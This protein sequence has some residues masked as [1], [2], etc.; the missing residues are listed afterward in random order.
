MLTVRKIDERD[1]ESLRNIS[2]QTFNETFF[3][4]NSEQDMQQYI[5]ESLNEERLLFELQNLDSEFYFAEEEGK[6]LGYLKLNFN[7]AQT[8]NFDENHYEVERIYVLKE[9]LRMKIGQF[10]F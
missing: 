3:E 9:F 8:E 6:V 1:L 4:L 7:T 2:I 5:S 10:L